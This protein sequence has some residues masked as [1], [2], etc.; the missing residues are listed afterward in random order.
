MHR[1]V[2]S[3]ASLTKIGDVKLRCTLEVKSCWKSI[4]RILPV[5]TERKYLG[6]FKSIGTAEGNY[7]KIYPVCNTGALGVKKTAESCL[8]P[9]SVTISRDI[10]L[11]AE[12]NAS[13]FY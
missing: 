8:F 9:Q 6:Y 13:F 7:M 12:V 1:M 11:N 3:L 10:F 2:L 4:I 5:F